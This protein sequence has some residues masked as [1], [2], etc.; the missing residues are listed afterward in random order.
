[1]M[2][3]VSTQTYSG[4]ENIINRMY[5]RHYRVLEFDSHTVTKPGSKDVRKARADCGNNDFS[6][7]YAGNW[8]DRGK[9]ECVTRESNRYED[10]YMTLPSR[11][12]SGGEF[13]L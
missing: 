5:N 11:S 2:S 9:T 10:V 1:M 13:C 4:I 6:A 8:T 7:E 12:L 3:A